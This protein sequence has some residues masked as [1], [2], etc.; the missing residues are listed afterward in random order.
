MLC[1]SV[2]VWPGAPDPSPKFGYKVRVSVEGDRG[3]PGREGGETG[4]RRVGW[5][6]EGWLGAGRGL[7]ELSVAAHC[8]GGAGRAGPSKFACWWAGALVGSECQFLGRA[9]G[10]GGTPEFRTR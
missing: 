5:V 7:W 2:A 8:R 1:S 3:G 9:P 6:S 10:G 4:D